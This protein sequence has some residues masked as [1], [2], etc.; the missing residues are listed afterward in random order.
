MCD[1][2]TTDW[3]AAHTLGTLATLTV[4]SVLTGVWVFSDR[5]LVGKVARLCYGVED[6]LETLIVITAL[7]RGEERFPTVLVGYVWSNILD[8][9]IKRSGKSVIGYRE[10]SLS[11]FS[12][13]QGRTVSVANV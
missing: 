10:V 5:T 8:V 4:A 12:E 7:L 11:L 3:V 6:F 13:F 1:S 2:T 9:V